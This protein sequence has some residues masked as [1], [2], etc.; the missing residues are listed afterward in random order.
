MPLDSAT[1]C[2]ELCKSDTSLRRLLRLLLLHQGSLQLPHLLAGVLAMGHLVYEDP[3]RRGPYLQQTFALLRG[4]LMDAL[5]AQPQDAFD[6]GAAAQLL[7]ASA[8]LQVPPTAAQQAALEAAAV[9]GMGEAT[10]ASLHPILAA[11]QALNLQ[12]ASPATAAALQSAA[13][14]LLH[15]AAPVQLRDSLVAWHGRGWA[16]T[17]ALAAAAEGRALQLLRPE[18]DTSSEGVLHL[19]EGF[20]QAR[21]AF[22]PSPE[23]RAA[24]RLGVIQHLE[25]APANVASGALSCC[26]KMGLL[27]DEELLAAFVEAA[28]RVLPV[29]SQ[30]AF[31]FVPRLLMGLK[32]QVRAG[33]GA[34]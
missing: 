30:E 4:Q 18:E 2:T 13:E 1:L 15:A 23:L 29:D 31:A 34:G 11:Y 10:V 12:P 19:L 28:P 22:P 6:V 24:L 27:P 17:P 7:R 16:V 5:A 26:R 33:L 20:T 32:L 9:R 14:F 3:R 21:S 25:T 8:D